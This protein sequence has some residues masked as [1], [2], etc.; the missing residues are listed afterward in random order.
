MKTLTLRVPEDLLD[1]SSEVLKQLGLDVPIAFRLFLTQVAATRS[2]PFALKAR[3]VSW[4]TVPVD[5]AT[6]RAMDAIGSLW[7]Q[8]DPRP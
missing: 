1:E 3:D 2:I 8:Q 4:E 7:S 5:A 6:Q